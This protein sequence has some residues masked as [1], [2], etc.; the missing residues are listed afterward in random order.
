MTDEDENEVSAEDALKELAE[1]IMDWHDS[2][3]EQIDEILE[4]GKDGKGIKLRNE[5]DDSEI[6]IEGDKMAGFMAGL[7]VAKLI[8]GKL[9]FTLQD[10]TESWDDEAEKELT[11]PEEEPVRPENFGHFS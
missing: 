9:P 7:H 6:V 3:V 1:T 8:L 4:S 2:R 11:E 5:E 10:P